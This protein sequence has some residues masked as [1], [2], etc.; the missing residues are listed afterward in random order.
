MLVLPAL[1]VLLCSTPKAEPLLLPVAAVLCFQPDD[2]QLTAFSLAMLPILCRR[3]KQG[4]WFTASLAFLL[5]CTLWC[6]SIPTT[7]EP[8][9]YCEGILDM[10]GHFSPMLKIAGWMALILIPAWF[11][12]CFVRC[13]TLW[14]LC[15]A[16]YYLCAILFSING[17]Y[18]VPFMG[19]G[20][21]TLGGYWLVYLLMP[22]EK[23]A[24]A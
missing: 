9:A 14:T 4:I 16:V 15:L 2:S 18:P 3:R 6:I 20:I 5:I 7:L 12:W 24:Q 21:S 17:Q 22:D 13:R 19:F 11:V 10:L 23:G 1:I 8:V